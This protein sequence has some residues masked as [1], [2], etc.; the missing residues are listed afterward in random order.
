MSMKKIDKYDTFRYNDYK[1]VSKITFAFLLTDLLY[2]FLFELYTQTQR[3]FK[4]SQENFMRKIVS[5]LVVLTLFLTLLPAQHADAAI[6]DEEILRIG[7]YTGSNALQEAKLQNVNRHGDGYL[8]GTMSSYDEF[9]EYGYVSDIHISMIYGDTYHVL[10]PNAYW[11]YEEASAS[12]QWY[13][14]GFVRYA[15]GYFYVLIGTYYS[16]GDAANAALAYGGDFTSCGCHSNTISVI[17]TNSREILFQFRSS[18]EKLAVMPVF[19]NGT[20]YSDDGERRATTWHK[21]NQYRGIFEYYL[22]G[23]LINTVNV[24][25]MN[26][27]IKGVIPYEMSSSWPIEALKAQALCA[28]TYA[29]YNLGKHTSGD[30]DLCATTC[31]QVYRGTGSANSHTDTAV[32]ETAGMYITYAGEPINAVYCSSNGGATENCENVWTKPLAYLRAVKDDFEQ[33]VETGYSDWSYTITLSEITS[34]L[35]ERG[36]TISGS[37]VH[38]YAVYTDAGNVGELHFI[39]SSGREFVY[40][41][42]SCRTVFNT[43][44]SPIKI[45]SQRYIFEDAADPR[46]E[47]C[48]QITNVSAS[49]DAGSTDVGESSTAWVLTDSGL[50]TAHDTYGSSVPILTA[51]GIDEAISFYT[52]SGNGLF[53][54][55]EE[56]ISAADLN[57]PTY[58]SGTFIIRG[59]GWGHNLGLSQYGAKAMAELGY[60]AEDIIHYYY[61]N[62]TIESTGFFDDGFDDFIY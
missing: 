40:R 19:S 32:D 21:S 13:E 54:P 43:S 34:I 51:D 58:S 10:D 17:N 57:I 37:I 9:I 56:T 39:D 1:M 60:T 18:S 33:Y 52:T 6:G 28:R 50:S 46:I 26:D 16:S 44:G 20:W 8:L 5:I 4:K 53:T 15:E 47:S 35:R 2:Y 62:V 38:A 11:T 23:T 29:L 30:F 22:T 27:Y 31:C 45:Y 24:V 49:I 48:A 61:S 59:S 7:L 25:S 41:G 12:A 36:N 14:G 42:E 55:G 3:F